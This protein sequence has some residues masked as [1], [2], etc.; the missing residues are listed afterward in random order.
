MTTVATPAP[1]AM[2]GSFIT[3]AATKG[4]FITPTAMKDPFIAGPPPSCRTGEV[5]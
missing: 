3:P 2:K 5:R 4:S 1:R